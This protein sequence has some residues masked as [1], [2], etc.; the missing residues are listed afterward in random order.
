VIDRTR[1]P[2]SS[3]DQIAADYVRNLSI[4]F[5]R[6]EE[7]PPAPYPFWALARTVRD[8]LVLQMHETKRAHTAQERRRTHYL[9][10][11]Y[12]LGRLLANASLN[13]DISDETREAM[14]L[15]G[16]DLEDIEAQEQDPGL[17][18]GGLGRLAACFLDSCATT[19]LPV[20]GYGLRYRYGLFVQK[21]LGGSQ[22]EE[23]DTWLTQGF[24]WE[25]RRNELRQ[26]VRFG[27]RT[28]HRRD[29]SGQLRVE[30]VDTHDVIAE[31]Y[32]VPVPG[33]RNG[34]VNTLRLWSA[35]AIE[36]FDLEEFNAGS[37]PAAVEAQHHAEVITA[38]LYP[39][40]ANDVGR[41]LRLR[42]E[43]FL[44]A[45]TLADCFRR[46]SEGHGNDVSGFATLNRFQLNDT[47]PSLLIPELMRILVDEIGCNWDT[48]WNITS[49]CVAYT[50]HTLLPEALER[51]PVEL[52]GR[53][54]PRH[55]EIIYEI[56][57]RFLTT[58]AQ[59]WPGDTDRQARMSI[60][61]ESSDQ[62]VRMG[63]LAVVGSF[64]VNGVA[65]LHS[66][67]IRSELFHDFAQLWPERFT[68]VTN[69]VTPRRWVAECNPGLA[70]LITERI[71]PGW[72]T[73]LS[74]LAELRAHADDPDFRTR[75][76]AVRRENKERLA[77]LIRDRV[78][79]RVDPSALFDV[80][81]KRIHEYKRQLMNVLH[82]IHLYCRIRT[83]RTEGMAPRVIVLGGVA[84]PGYQV[85]KRI[86]KLANNVAAV[87][88]NDPAVGDLLKLVFVPGYNVSTMQAICPGTDLSSQISTAGKEASGTGNM[89]FMMN[90]AVTIG[91]LDGANV[92][93]RD[94]VGEEN[95][96]VFGATVAEARALREA[97]DPTAIARAD[98]DLTE[99]LTLL[100]SG[101]FNQFQSGIFDELIAGILSPSDPWLTVA[102]FA[103][104]RQAH[105]RAAAAFQDRER[106]LDMSIANAAASGHFSSD[107]SIAEYNSEIWG[108]QPITATATV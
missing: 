8:R 79:V 70:R 45:A 81:V 87:V 50:N 91:T 84:A 55:L 105:E 93:I 66:E 76:V 64:S 41:E 69:G 94:R 85:A 101:H 102:D 74:E 104:F 36:E 65:E 52:L 22:V 106:W 60:I 6:E 48:A 62:K 43:Y 51:W 29:H 12:L 59:R 33:Y 1:P 4:D 46:W 100:R 96:F 25:L 40:D 98:A 24:P 39:N 30:W 89:K 88:N 27:G 3:P 31:P 23:S 75:W 5:A 14:T 77:H 2:D 7:H 47:H 108:L 32:D 83:G 49:G 99:V 9:S 80:Q 20:I 15:L 78:G 56:N 68:N 13:L 28:E 67:L 54:L 21:I 26:L 97:Y 10:L 90:G 71:G 61:E 18:N 58:V 19:G 63:H 34:V 92:E 42:Q 44:V 86:I 16:L 37:F 17:G 82:A 95:F 38:V 35:S 72:L 107:R 11:E 57:A 73:D 53:L 103:S